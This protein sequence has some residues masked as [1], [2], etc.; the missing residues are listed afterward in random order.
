MMAGDAGGAGVGKCGGVEY[1]VFA[2]IVRAGAAC[3]GGVVTASAEKGEIE[4]AVAY[5]NAAKGVE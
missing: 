4:F 5:V 3:D 2:N 1:N